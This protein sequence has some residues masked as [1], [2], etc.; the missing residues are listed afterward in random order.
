MNNTKKLIT[1]GVAWNLITRGGANVINLIFSI[2]LA[3]LLL[4]EI[5]GLV[6]M[7]TLFSGFARILFSFGF[8]SAIIRDEKLSNDSYSTIFWFNIIFGMIIFIIFI[9]GSYLIARFYDEPILVNVTRIISINFILYALYIVPETLLR[10]KLLFKKISIIHIISTIFSSVFAILL[11]LMNYGIWS[12]VAK[13]I[14]INLVQLILIFWIS[15]WR[16]TIHFKIN[17]IKRIFKFGL[18]V[19]LN[20]SLTYW[21]RKIDNLIV[22]KALGST[23]LGLYSNAYNL[24][25]FPIQHI[26]KNINTVMFPS[27]SYVNNDYQVKKIFLKTTQ[28]ITLLTVPL[29]VGLS[30]L[31][32]QF[33]LLTYGEKWIAMIVPLRI[34]ALAGI[35]Q[36]ILALNP[37]IYLLKGRAEIPLMLNLFKIPILV[38]SILVGIRVNGLV[39]LCYS[40]LIAQIIF[41]FPTFHFSSKLIRLS[42]KEYFYNILPILLGSLLIM[43]I[44]KLIIFIIGDG[45][46]LLILL[47]SASSSVLFMII[48]CILFKIESYN[49]VLDYL[50]I[51]LK[52]K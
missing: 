13:L 14:S 29:L 26:A 17:E 34:L 5:F 37:S 39:G 44:T 51:K 33:V 25:M 43:I 22:G 6:A 35:P 7:V 31:S 48:W 36:T 15:K 19:T 24:M 38:I 47:L 45:N 42:F 4:P 12:I 40:Y 49:Q 23:N 9:P 11:A 41:Y 52:L 21:G 8:S 46:N 18:N 27:F 28:L 1:D 50:R 20:N 30:T 16:P 2:V 3:R 32:E 10:K